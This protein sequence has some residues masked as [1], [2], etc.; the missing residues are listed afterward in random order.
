MLMDVI[1]QNSIYY[2][3]IKFHQPTF[4]KGDLH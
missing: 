3:R 4:T 1:N 2:V